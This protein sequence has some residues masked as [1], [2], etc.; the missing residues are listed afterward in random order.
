MAR[1]LVI[2]DDPDTAL[3][4]QTA[5]SHHGHE[6]H[7]SSDGHHALSVLEAL[8]PDLLLVDIALP[9]KVDGWSVVEYVAQEDEPLPCIV[10]TAFSGPEHR[11]RADALA[12][13]RFLTKPVAVAELIS[14]VDAVVGGPPTPPP[15]PPPPPSRG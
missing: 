3:V 11:E 13:A 6:V 4:Y 9:G 1:V 12:C 15:S 10:A 14:A 2:E 8:R 5:L 7:V